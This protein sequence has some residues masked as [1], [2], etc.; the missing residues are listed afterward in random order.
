VSLKSVV[1]VGAL[2]F[3]VYKMVHKVGAD[4]DEKRAEAQSAPAPDV[5]ES[6]GDVSVSL[7]LDYRENKAIATNQFDVLNAGMINL[8][9]K[10]TNRGPAARS[11][12][13]VVRWQDANFGAPEQMEIVDLG[14]FEAGETRSFDEPFA[15]SLGQS[16]QDGSGRNYAL[17]YDIKLERVDLR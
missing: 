10:V 15:N 12:E 1:I 11:I 2:A 4:F 9:G 7:A 5:G 14:P 16:T 13:V 6:R 3:G 8:R 17:K